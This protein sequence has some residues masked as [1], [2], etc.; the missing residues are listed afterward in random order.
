MNKEIKEILINLVYETESRVNEV[1]QIMQKDPS[2]LEND[3]VFCALCD[4]LAAN[5]EMF[6]NAK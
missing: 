3:K 6:N 1:Y 4:Q 5:I 2:D